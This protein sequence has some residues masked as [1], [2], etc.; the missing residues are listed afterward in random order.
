MCRCLVGVGSAIVAPVSV[1]EQSG[2]AVVLVKVKV[3]GRN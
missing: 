1:V 3:E 2:C